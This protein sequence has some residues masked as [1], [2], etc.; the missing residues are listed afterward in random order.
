MLGAEFKHTDEPSTRLSRL[1]RELQTSFAV[2]TIRFLE[3]IMIAPVM[4]K[5][6]ARETLRALRS[7]KVSNRERTAHLINLIDAFVPGLATVASRHLYRTH[8]LPFADQHPQLIAY[9]K[10]STVFRLNA[11]GEDRV[12]KIYRRS[13]GKH[14]RE[15]FDVLNSYRQKYNMVCEWYN[16]PFEMVI[17]SSFLIVNGPVLNQP[18]AAS[19]QPYVGRAKRDL[20][21]DFT[22]AELVSM[23]REDDHLRDQFIYFASRTIHAYTHYRVVLDL[24]GYENV[25][26]IENDGQTNLLVLDPGVLSLDQLRTKRPVKIPAIREV[27][28][29]LQGLLKAV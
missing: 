7:G 16:G 11:G 6:S 17:P 25:V 13:L 12:L 24:L 15:L 21:Y 29:R 9:G 3:G 10:G 28:E 27:M 20:L 26:L 4:T 14:G 22:D 2:V 5:R 23:M 8:A 1:R 18:V 19:V